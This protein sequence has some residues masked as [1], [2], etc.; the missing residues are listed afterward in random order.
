VP[1]QWQASV[2]LA[3]AQAEIATGNAAGALP[4]L[5][6]AVAAYTGNAAVYLTRADLN[7]AEGEFESA[8]ADYSAAIEVLE[9]TSASNPSLPAA[10]VGLGQALLGLEQPAAAIAAFEAA[11]RRAPEDFAAQLGL[12]QALLGGERPADA[13]AA[14]T[15][16]LELAAT[17]AQRTQTYY[18]RAQAHAAAGDPAAE[19]ADLAAL[20]ALASAS[21]PLAPTAEARL[22]EI[23]P[24]PTAT[25]DATAQAAATGTAAA[26]A[27]ATRTATPTATRTATRT[28]TSTATP[29]ATP[30]TTSTATPTATKTATP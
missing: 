30:T 27:T 29:T 18:W 26:R 17:N 7:L 16:A 2:L 22:T 23:G 6:Q 28:A 24:L 11:L 1:A 25:L 9:D 8:R 14:L 15:A 4:L 19:A 10:Y 13:V 20:M 21:D 5:D 12:G 3:T